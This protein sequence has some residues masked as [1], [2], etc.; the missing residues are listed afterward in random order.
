MLSLKAR[1]RILAPEG[2]DDMNWQWCG[3]NAGGQWTWVE[4]EVKI[5]TLVEMDPGPDG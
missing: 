3:E 4:P 5:L 1:L 2:T